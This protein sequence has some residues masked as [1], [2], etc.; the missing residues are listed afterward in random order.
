MRTILLALLLG[1]I[2]SNVHAGEVSQDVA[3]KSA[4]CASTACR[5]PVRRGVRVVLAAPARIVQAGAC[6]VRN[7][8][9]A[10]KSAAC[11]A[12]SRVKTRTACRQSRR[13]AFISRRSCC[14]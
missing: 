7:A 13:A 11:N 5:Q 4:P 2:G 3:V 9:C 12:R 14:N 1:F 10:V 8:A 6:V